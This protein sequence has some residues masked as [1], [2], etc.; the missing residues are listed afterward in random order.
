MVIICDGLNV[1]AQN[2]TDQQGSARLRAPCGIV[3]KYTLQVFNQGFLVDSEPVSFHLLRAILPFHRSLQADEYDWRFTLVDTW[4]LPPAVNITPQ[5]SSSEMAQPTKLFA[6]QQGLGTYAYAHLP[7][8]VYR[9]QLQYKSFRVEQ[10]ITIP[11]PEASYVF[12]ATFPVTFQIVDARGLGLTDA[13]IRINRS[14]KTET[15]SLNSSSAVISLPP[16]DYAVSV[17]SHDEIISKRPVTVSSERTVELITT[18]EPLFPLMSIICFAVLGAILV[19]YGTIKK[20]LVMLLVSLAAC[21]AVIACM[22][23]WWSLGGSTSD[24]TTSSTL[25]LTPPAFVTITRTA[26]VLTGELPYL[27][28]LFTTIL[29]VILVMIMLGCLLCGASLVFQRIQKLKMRLFSILGAFLL[30]GGGLVM[31]LLAITLYSQVSVGS[32]LGAG[33]VGISIPGVNEQSLVPCHWGPA[34]GFF[35]FVLVVILLFAALILLVRKNRRLKK[36]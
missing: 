16:G 15:R 36:V 21:L 20:D 1:I 9:L 22:L 23:P 33:I 14:G 25:Y 29:L 26:T 8:A 28:D 5:L 24:I 13:T 3:K 4:G 6:T 12:S 10:N 30:F 32:V 7:P 2:V 18:Q 11:A 27:P 31:F 17:V 34:A 35:V 19:G